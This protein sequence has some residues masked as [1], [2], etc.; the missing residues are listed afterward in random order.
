MFKQ[1]CNN[2]NRTKNFNSTFSMYGI[3]CQTEK[4]LLW[5]QRINIKKIYMTFA[6]VIITIKLIKIV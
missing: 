2:H 3:G 1:L 4:L 6:K 5:K